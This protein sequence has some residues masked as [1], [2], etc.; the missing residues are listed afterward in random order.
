MPGRGPFLLGGAIPTYG[1]GRGAAGAAY[2]G[3]GF[4]V[5]GIRSNIDKGIPHTPEET[6]EI[7]SQI[8]T[9]CSISLNPYTG[10]QARGK[11]RRICQR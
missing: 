5:E 6:D 8:D 7:D 1:A 11:A 10:R 4:T 3:G 9:N 2:R